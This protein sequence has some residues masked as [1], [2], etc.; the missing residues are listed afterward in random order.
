[1]KVILLENI[2]RVGRKGDI[3]EVAP[4][5]A[6]NY[7]FPRK[8]ALE[9]TQSNIK[10]V[11]MQ[12]KALKKKLEKE[13]LTSQELI[14]KL[15]EVTLTFVRRSSE[16]DV[17]FGS[18]SAADIHDQLTRLGFEIDKKKIMLDEPI[19]RLG[20]FTVPIKVYHEDRAEIKVVVTKEESPAEVSEPKDQKDDQA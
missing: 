3:L 15:N 9:V 19:K 4:G 5:Y 8:L 11:E 13:R 2:E 18:V 7:L 1:M 6:R 17:I 20:T 12:Q 14:K 16:K 10:A